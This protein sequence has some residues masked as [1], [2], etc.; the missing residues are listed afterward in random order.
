MKIY[1]SLAALTGLASAID[2]NLRRGPHAD[3]RFLD[4]EPLDLDDLS[5]DSSLSMASSAKGGE[6]KSSEQ[7]SKGSKTKSA[8]T[9]ELDAVVVGSGLAGLI[10]ARDMEAAG[11]EVQVLEAQ[12]YVGG[13]MVRKEL[14]P[15][16]SVDFGGQWVGRTHSLLQELTDELNLTRFPAPSTSPSTTF[17]EG[18]VAGN[19]ST[20]FAIPGFNVPGFISDGQACRGA[21]QA[22]FDMIPPDTYPFEE[23]I[24]ENETLRELDGITVAAFVDGID[25]ETDLGRVFCTGAAG[26][27]NSRTAGPYPGEPE[28]EYPEEQLIEGAAGQIPPIL[29]GK[30]S[31][32]VRLSDPVTRISQMLV[33]DEIQATVH[34]QAGKK[35]MAKNVV[36]ATSPYISGLIS[37]DPPV[38]WERHQLNQ[39]KPMGT[40]AK[41]LLQY[42]E[43]FWG[44]NDG[45]LLTGI[46]DGM[47][48]ICI[49]AT[50]Q[51]SERGIYVC[52]ITG[53]QY[54]QFVKS[55]E[56]NEERIDAVLNELSRTLGQEALSP[57]TVDIGNWPVNPFVQ[58]SYSSYWP[59]LAWTRFG[60]ALLRP[61]G[62]IQ[63]CSTEH[64]LKWHGYFEGAIESGMRAAKDVIEGNIGE[65][66]EPEPH[67]TLDI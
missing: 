55:G 62:V 34:T 49:D 24:A 39:H 54:D 21:F 56:T 59:P 45:G 46:E 37:Y 10:A 28:T 52:L 18:G 5:S 47:L 43:R 17:I 9:T 30:L 12:D 61:E 20:I 32:P 11:L 3:E 40:V 65:L 26:Y 50:D 63:W 22:V 36:V 14:S 1:A 57:L 6:S 27:G 60:S 13:R 51:R 25:F 42:E 15:T 2:V 23:A 31:R 44:M 58:G 41:I 33:G 38:S 48:S 8:K 29:A 4:V 19:F 7:G 53:K 66:K 35:Y 64:A 16:Q 67:I